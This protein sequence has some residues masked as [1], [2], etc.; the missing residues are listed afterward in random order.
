MGE[1]PLAEEPG[2]EA[3]PSRLSVTR[4]KLSGATRMSEQGVE[5][6]FGKSE[7]ATIGTRRRKL[8]T[9]WLVTRQRICIILWEDPDPST[10]TQTVQR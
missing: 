5:L 3:R 2:V 6:G 10:T 8:S 7:A 4:W 1:G 9:S